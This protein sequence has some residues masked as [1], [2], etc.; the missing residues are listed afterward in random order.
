M[1]VEMDHP[2]FGHM[3]TLGVPVKMSETP[4]AVRGRAPLLGEHTSQVLRE[5]GFS[6]AEITELS[7]FGA[8]GT[9][10]KTPNSS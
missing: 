1:V 9:Q 8:P 7:K 3:K 10:K 2:T 5:S 6:E 4:P